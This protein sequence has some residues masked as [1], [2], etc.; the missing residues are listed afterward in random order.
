MNYFN[1]LLC[2][3]IWILFNNLHKCTFEAVTFFAV[4]TTC[5]QCL[6][7]K[8]VSLN[9]STV[10]V[11][12]SGTSGK[13]GVARYIK[14]P[15]TWGQRFSAGLREGPGRWGAA[16]SAGCGAAPQQGGCFSQMRSGG[17]TGWRVVAVAAICELPPSSAPHLASW[18]EIPINR[19]F[20]LLEC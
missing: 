3:N 18:P 10:K 15:V 11:L 6:E 14:I 8:S 19:V 13:W 17:R 7:D 12:F 20:C 4:F 5:S 2:K 1:N 9:Q 16:A